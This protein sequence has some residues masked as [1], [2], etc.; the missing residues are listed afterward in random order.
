MSFNLAHEPHLQVAEMSRQEQ[1]ILELLTNGASVRSIAAFIGIDP[2]DAE[3]LVRQML[4]KLGA[5][6]TA[7]LVRLGLEARFARRS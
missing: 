1:E 2:S 3:H 7:D 6:G 5:V 4:A